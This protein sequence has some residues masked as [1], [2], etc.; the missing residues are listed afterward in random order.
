MPRLTR[1]L[2]GRMVDESVVDPLLQLLG[3]PVNEAVWAQAANSSRD[4]Q[5][6][7]PTFQVSRIAGLLEPK[8][9]ARRN[10]T[11]I[12]GRGCRLLDKPPAGSVGHAVDL[13][14]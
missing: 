3:L 10:V 2:N 14:R 8:W 9:M 11:I 4:S 12:G 6:R 13:N 7:R 5:R 1:L